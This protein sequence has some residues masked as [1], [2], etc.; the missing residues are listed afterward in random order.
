MDPALER[1]LNDVEGAQ[2]LDIDHFDLFMDRLETAVVENAEGR[3]KHSETPELFYQS[4]VALYELVVQLG[5]AAVDLRILERLSGEG[6]LAL[7][8]PIINHPND[9]IS[10]SLIK[11]LLEITDL[12]VGPG[13]DAHYTW[14]FVVQCVQTL[15]CPLEPTLPNSLLEQEWSFRNIVGKGY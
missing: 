7:I 2:I 9:D 13:E 1:L 10:G 15:G 12:D 11:N 8:L 6:S 4:E 5:A 3:G 14:K